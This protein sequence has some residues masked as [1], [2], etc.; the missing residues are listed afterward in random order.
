MVRTQ[1]ALAA[2][3][4]DLVAIEVEETDGNSLPL[5]ALH[6]LQKV[7]SG[8][9]QAVHRGD[10]EGVTLT[11]P[12][13]GDLKLLALG[14]CRDTLSEQLLAPLGLERSYL[15]VEAR[16]LVFARRCGRIR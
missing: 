5:Q 9:R 13:K 2:V 15:G 6:D 1:P 16:E 11:S 12:G 8:A 7:L 3:G 4:V 14:C 10:H